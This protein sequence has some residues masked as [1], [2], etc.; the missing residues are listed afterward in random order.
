M[1]EHYIG[2]LME[3]HMRNSTSTR[4]IVSVHELPWEELLPGVKRKRIWGEP[5]WSDRPVPREMSMV[6]FEP[7]VRVPLH[8]HVGG[9]EI[10]FVIEGVLSDEYGDLVAGN[11]GFR[12]EGCTHSLRSEAGATTLSFLLGSAEMNSTR[13]GRGPA[14]LNIDVNTMPWEPRLH[15]CAHV[16]SIW[17]DSATDRRLLMYKAP[18]THRIDLGAYTA[19]ELIYQIEG[20][21]VDEAGL[22]RAGDVGVRPT[23]CDHSF[24][25]DN[26]AVGLAYIWGKGAH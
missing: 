18:A 10:V 14:C 23:G 21:V 1:P 12:P 4:R 22:L 6:R 8:R 16:K 2:R 17:Q 25:S 20:A 5:V 19:E 15:G 7:G 26:G 3:D 13:P 11:V 9:D 24:I